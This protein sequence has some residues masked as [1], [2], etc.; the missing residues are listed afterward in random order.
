M[1]SSLSLLLLAL[2]A[3][4]VAEAG[5]RVF[6]L[7]ATDLVPDPIGPCDGYVKLFL[8]SAKLG[9]TSVIDNDDNPWWEEEFAYLTARQHDV[10]RLEVYDRDLI[11]DDLVGI[12]ETQIKKGNY[13]Y[14]CN[15]DDDVTLYFSTTLS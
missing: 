10:L 11:Y 12:C 6:N 4:T 7:R 15:L 13:V 2:C 9:T 5:L 8:G 1:A 3:L 14:Y